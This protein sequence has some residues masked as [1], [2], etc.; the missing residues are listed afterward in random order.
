MDSTE[1]GN[2]SGDSVAGK[3]YT[4]QRVD[5]DTLD[6]IK[7]LNLHLSRRGIR[8][9]QSDLIRMAF[10]FIKNKEWEFIEFI[11]SGGAKKKSGGIFDAV[12]DTVSR[13]WFPYGDFRS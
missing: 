5:L 1:E 4:T 10:L 7:T 3:K 12:F 8:L 11:E 2:T 13:P 9:K 6:L